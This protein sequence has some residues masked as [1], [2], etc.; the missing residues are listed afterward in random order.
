MSS[1]PTR[2]LRLSER[3]FLGLFVAANILVPLLLIE[4]YPFTIAP[5]YDTRLR[6]VTLYAVRGPSGQP[7]PARDF[8]LDI[9]N[10]GADGTATSPFH[11]HRARIP[12]DSVNI[13]GQPPL[14][15][16]ALARRVKQQ[17]A[18]MSIPWVIITRT[19]L[20]AVDAE[21]AGVVK[22]EEMRVERAP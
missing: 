3:V 21:R 1:S 5:M 14:A 19:T 9:A 8:G 13:V 2:G 15:P 17:L 10:L 7:L 16:Q 20:G 22:V 6:E 18:A 12:F 11:R 4:F